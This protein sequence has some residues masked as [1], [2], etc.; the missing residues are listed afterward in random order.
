L[1]RLDEKIKREIKI[2]FMGLKAIKRDI[3]KILSISI[4]ITLVTFGVLVFL[5]QNRSAFGFLRGALV[6]ALN[7]ALLYV[8]ISKTLK[9]SF[10][11][12]FAIAYGSYFIRLLLISATLIHSII[13]SM[14]VFI[15][16]IL[17][18]TVIKVVIISNT[19]FGRWSMWNF[20]QR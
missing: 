2:P 10:E 7:F 18:L 3:I 12:A 14:D 5:K 20:F 4:V 17:G 19:I 15:S 1:R 6:S 13:T 11:R 16:S 8:I 9:S